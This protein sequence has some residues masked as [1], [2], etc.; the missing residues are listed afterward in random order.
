MTEF[1]CTSCK[2]D[3]NIRACIEGQLIEMLL[4]VNCSD[5]GLYSF[6]C[7]LQCKLEALEMV[8]LLVGLYILVQT[9]IA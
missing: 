3:G 6:K 1:D 2:L 8:R 7:D 9:L 5:Y 4:V